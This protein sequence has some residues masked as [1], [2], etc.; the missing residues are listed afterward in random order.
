LD[1]NFKGLSFYLASATIPSILLPIDYSSVII[2]LMVMIVLIR[3]FKKELNLSNK[4]KKFLLP[5]LIYFLAIFISFVLDLYYGY[6]NFEIFLKNIAVIIIPIFIFSSNFA[7]KT[8]LKILKTSFI[9]VSVM[10]LLMIVIWAYGYAV[11]ISQNDLINDAWEK[12]DNIS[13]VNI[14]RSS[15]KLKISNS[16]EDIAS[17]RRIIPLPKDK[18]IDSI[19]RELDF[20]INSKENEAGFWALI[21]PIDDNL[22]RG[23][24]VNMK[25]DEIG[26]SNGVKAKIT[27]LSSGFSRIVVK[28]K[29]SETQTKEWFYISF[30]DGDGE[31]RLN[32]DSSNFEIYLKEP[33][34]YLNRGKS[35]LEKQNLLKYNIKEFSFLDNYA[36]S[37]YMGLVFVFA[38]IFILFNPDLFNRYIRILLILINGFII[39]ALASKAIILGVLLIFPFFFY[40]RIS[41]YKIFALISALLILLILG[42]GHIKNRFVDMYETLTNIESIEGSEKF[43]E[44][45]KLSTKQRY[46]IYSNYLEL[47]QDNY[48]SGYGIIKG[49]KIVKSKFNHDF[50]AHNQFLQSIY[51]TGIIGFIFLLIFSFSP[52]IIFKTNFIDNYGIMFFILIILFNFLF[53]SI[54]YRQWGLILMSFSLSVYYQINKYKWFQ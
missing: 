49:K 7:L 51:N 31:Y 20:K 15:L 53:E 1:F 38:I 26:K 8:M 33:K 43:E 48:L 19:T 36:H 47:V 21:R 30:V 27:K 46:D 29:V 42:G 12:S 17:L 39:Y 35:L 18:K 45:S 52:L 5:F 50:N 41:G 34:A 2:I 32:N 22:Q 14:P 4:N 16:S 28:N 9:I 40:K 3:F 54:L 11:N 44:L 25:T 24:W 10:G 6:L 37:T 13:L 23:V